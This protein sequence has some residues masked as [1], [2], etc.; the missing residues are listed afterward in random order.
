MFVA[1]V[2]SPLCLACRRLADDTVMEREG[3][4]YDVLYGCS[5]YCSCTCRNTVRRCCIDMLWS[6]LVGGYVP[7]ALLSAGRLCCRQQ[8]RPAC[9]LAQ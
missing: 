3:Q 4:A 5:T 8:S 6:R 9:C 2:S 7:K 1:A